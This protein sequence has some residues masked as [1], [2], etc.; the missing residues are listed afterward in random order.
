MLVVAE[1]LLALLLVAFGSLIAALIPLAVG[2]L[3]IATTLAITGFL[4]HRWHLSI[5]VQNLATMLGLG[6]GIDYGL[7]MVSRF[8]EAISTGISASVTSLKLATIATL[9]S[10][11][12]GYP[13]AYFL[14]RFAGRWSGVFVFIVIAPL[15]TSIIMRTFGW[16]VLLARRGVYR[17]LYDLQFVD[18]ERPTGA[19]A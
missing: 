13:V 4:A 18:E 14:A 6:L 10:L 17:R 9:A 12:V 7:L 2:Q 1:A 11:V 16:R 8:R 3:A 5:L 15:L 19:L